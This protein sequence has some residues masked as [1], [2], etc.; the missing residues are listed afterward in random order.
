ML[1]GRNVMRIVI[2]ATMARAGSIAVVLVSVG[3]LVIAGMMAIV[4]IAATRAEA[5]ALTVAPS[6][7]TPIKH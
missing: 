1:L 5:G 7:L 4:M 6:T 3:I 2:R